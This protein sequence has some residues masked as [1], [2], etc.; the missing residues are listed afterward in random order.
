MYRLMYFPKGLYQYTGSV[1]SKD[2]MYDLVEIMVKKFAPVYEIMVIKFE[3]FTV[4]T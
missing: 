2:V 4:R 3:C 1:N